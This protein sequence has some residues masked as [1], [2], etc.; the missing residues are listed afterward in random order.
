VLAY[1]GASGPTAKDVNGGVGTETESTPALEAT[2][3]TRSYPRVKPELGEGS[4]AIASVQGAQA[5]S[6]AEPPLPTGPS[7]TTDPD[8]DDSISKEDSIYSLEPT[9]QFMEWR[10]TWADEAPGPSWE[11]LRT[12]LPQLI[13]VLH[14][15]AT[16]HQIDCRETICQLYLHVENAADAQALFATM[17]RDRLRVEHEQLAD[18]VQLE[19]SPSGGST[20]ELLIRRD[21]PASLPPHV[22]GA[23]RAYS[24][25]LAAREG[26][27]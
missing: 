24:E 15:A 17:S 27:E 14:S 22:P 16:L 18:D 23:M 21:R 3:R 19:H 4:A 5:G 10:R 12:Q 7:G 26:I 6:S 20:Y 1:E 2:H 13:G 9:T 8:D 11:A 25:A